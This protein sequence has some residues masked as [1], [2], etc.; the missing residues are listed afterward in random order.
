MPA[1]LL[2]LLLP[3]RSRACPAAAQVACL[4]SFFL[5]GEMKCGTTTM[6]KLL[7]SQQGV[8]APSLKEPRYLTLPKYRHYTGSWYA[9]HFAAAAAAPSA[10][11]FDASPTVFNSPLLA[12]GWVRKWL[13]DAR[14]IVLLREPTQRTYSHWR[15]GV[16]W[17]RASKCF[18]PPPANASAAHRG[19]EPQ[20][21]PEIRMMR[22]VFTFE[23]QVRRPAG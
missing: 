17:L 12:P 2:L 7:S 21:I 14:H 4:P 5:I 20:P 8:V 1:L 16:S 23:A 19:L 11:T 9:S 13:P 6:Y 3:L 15:M 18:V 22:E 10:I